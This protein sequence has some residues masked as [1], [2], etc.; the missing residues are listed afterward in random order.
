MKEN[1]YDTYLKEL[2]ANIR[3]IRKENGFTM[4]ALANEAEI[5]YRQLGRIERGEVNT[6]IISLLRI[7]DT[8]QVNLN[9]FFT[10]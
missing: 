2:G 1:R 10:F 6:T 4:E 5:E 7:A 9:E 8:L 3:R